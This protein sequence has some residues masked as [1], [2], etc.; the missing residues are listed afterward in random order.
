MESCL[1]QQCAVGKIMSKSLG[2]P[3]YLACC[4][5]NIFT[6]RNVLRYH[7]RIQ[8]AFGS[9]L[10]DELLMPLLYG[11]GG[12]LLCNP[13]L[14]LGLHVAMAIQIVREVDARPVAEGGRY[15]VGFRPPL[16]APSAS[17]PPVAGPPGS[18]SKR[19]RRR[20]PPRIE[21]TAL[22]PVELDEARMEAAAAEEAARRPQA[23]SRHDDESPS[24][25]QRVLAH[26]LQTAA[27]NISSVT[28][29]LRLPRWR[30][31]ELHISL[32]AVE[33]NEGGLLI[34]RTL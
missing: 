31:R 10:F 22:G 26:G 16:S 28:K 17:V 12:C 3:Y 14:C 9:D 20:R 18:I 25:M 11:C 4:C 29:Y 13:L 1:C 27:E 24:S 5:M 23:P 7:Y 30:S 21:V 34:Q 33:A 6:A 19:T 8:P 2:M 32:E 15:L